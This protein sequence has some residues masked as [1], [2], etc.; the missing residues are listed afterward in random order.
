MSRRL[1][2][3]VAA[4]SSFGFNVVRDVDGDG[5]IV[6]SSP[7]VTIELHQSGSDDVNDGSDLQALRDSMETWNQVACSAFRFVDGGTGTS[8]AIGA[9]GVSRIAFLESNWPG[10]ASG[11]AAFTLRERVSGNPDR[12]TEFDILVNGQDVRWTTDGHPQLPDIRSAVVHELGHGLG[13]QHAS[14]PEASMYFS[15]RLGTTF[16]RTLHPDDIAG[17]CYLYP[18]QTFSCGADSDCPVVHGSYGGGNYR[19]RC[20][21]GACVEGPAN[22]YGTGC[23][24]SDDCTSGLC[25]IDPLNPPSSE[26][27]FCSEACPSGTCPDG[28]YCA[29]TP[30]GPRCIV[31]RDDCAADADCGGNPN[32]CARQLD[33]RFVCQRLCLRNSA[34]MTVPGSVCHGGTGENPAG[35]CRVPGPGAPGTPCAHG[36]D[37]ASLNCSAGGVQPTCADGVPG[38][39]GEP[40]P[41]DAGVRD[42]S[43]PQT[44]AAPGFDVSPRDAGPVPLR[45]AATSVPGQDGGLGDDFDAGGRPPDLVSGGCVSVTTPT[46]GSALTALLFLALGLLGRGRSQRGRR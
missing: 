13:L 40:P 32:V 6:F 38:F 42:V 43:T 36:L 16:A 20:N 23:F 27:G 18:A 5:P 37:C 28:D 9:D 12:W 39:D 15:V 2:P 21:A 19:A 29:S 44:D 8:R 46:E 41:P 25:L 11:A 26:P 45:D 33:G 30:G 10:Y 31:G 1:L 4:A 7:T 35:F 22:S 34:C 3:L 24:E 14:H 17:A